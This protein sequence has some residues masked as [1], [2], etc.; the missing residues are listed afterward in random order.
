MIG[1]NAQPVTGGIE[2]VNLIGL[3][4]CGQE[5]NPFV[6]PILSLLPP[7]NDVFQLARRHEKTSE[8]KTCCQANDRARQEYRGTT[9]LECQVFILRVATQL[10]AQGARQSSHQKR[11]ANAHRLARIEQVFMTGLLAAKKCR[12][13]IH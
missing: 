2:P 9:A 1:T 13:S 12:E 5:I 7:Q 8:P 11:V 10:Y 6:S 3:P 4:Q